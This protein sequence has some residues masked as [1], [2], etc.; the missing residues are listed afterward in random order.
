MNENECVGPRVR[1]LFAQELFAHAHM[2]C[3]KA[4]PVKDIGSLLF[5]RTLVQLRHHP[6]Q[7]SAELKTCIPSPVALVNLMM[8][9]FVINAGEAGNR[10]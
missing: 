3:I 6:R 10:L 9:H 1:C 8:I 4:M 5:G 7:V 2:H